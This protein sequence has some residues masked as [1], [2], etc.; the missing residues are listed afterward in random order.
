MG[1]AVFVLPKVAPKG[2]CFFVLPIFFI[3]SARRS[4]FFVKSTPNALPRALV[5]LLLY[6]ARNNNNAPYRLPAALTLDKVSF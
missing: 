3:M 6:P 1:T 5:I 4:L 2:Y